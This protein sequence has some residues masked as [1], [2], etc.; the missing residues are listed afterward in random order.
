VALKDDTA[1][2]GCKA[3]K[4]KNGNIDERFGLDGLAGIL[5]RLNGKSDEKLAEEEAKRRD[6][7][8]MMWGDDGHGKG[9]VKFVSGGFLVGDRIVVKDAQEE[10][11]KKRK[12]DQIG[13][14]LSTDV[15]SNK[16]SDEDQERAAKKRRKEERK[17]QKLQKNP[18]VEANTT[19][20]SEAIEKTVKQ[21]EKAA[22]KIAK[23]ERRRARAER[24]AAKEAKRSSKKDRQTKESEE[25]SNTE[26][27]TG[28]I[29]VSPTKNMIDAP[30]IVEVVETTSI[31][32][33]LTP[34][35]P[36]RMVRQR[37]I[38]QKRMAGMDQKALNEVSILLHLAFPSSDQYTDYLIRYL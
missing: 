22:R 11:D 32:S 25:S 19:V 38:Q 35:H 30:S 9:R 23:E 16:A 17:L 20:D 33:T 1:G 15:A 2:L 3:G 8:L 18:S 13:D 14:E 31:I 36:T 26:E 4:G 7:K 21:T 24:R 10:N 5:G 28:V 27:E 12:R 37:Y 34:F 29:V 6:V